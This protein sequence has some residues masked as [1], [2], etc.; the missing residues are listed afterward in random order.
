MG[1]L[2][3]E[4]MGYYNL[5]MPYE[6]AWSILNRIGRLNSLQFVDLNPHENVFNRTYAQHI[7][8]CDEA[9]RRI[10]YL[11]LEQ[12]KFE[13]KTVTS[14]QVSVSP[15]LVDEELRLRD[16]PPQTYFEHLESELERLENTVADQTKKYEQLMERHNQLL[17]LRI[18]LDKSR[19]LMSGQSDSLFANLTGVMNLEDLNRFKR[20]V[21]RATR[22][23]ALTIAIDIEEPMKDPVSGL[24][25]PK[26][27]FIVRYRGN[28]EGAMRQNLVKIC[29]SLGAHRYN[30]PS[31]S[32]DLIKTLAQNENDIS[33]SLAI[34]SKTREQINRVLNELAA[35]EHF[36][37]CSILEEYRLFV[38]KE[39]S[40][41]HNLNMF[42]L[43][44][45]I[46]YGNCWLPLSDEPFVSQ[47]LSDL[48][49]TGLS[50]GQLRRVDG[51][52]P[53]NL[54][55]PTFFRL[56]AFTWAFQEMVNTYGTPRY[57]EANPA[58]FSCVT[59]PF[60]FGIM[61]GDV[62]HG[63]LLT[64]FAAYLCFKKDELTKSDSILKAAL[65]ARYMLLMMG[66]CAFYCGLIYNDFLGIPFDFFG[67]KWS[68]KSG[69]DQ[70]TRDEVYPFGM[71]PKW[72]RA[73]NE[74]IYFNS[75]KMKVAV[76]FGVTQ[77]T[78]GVL[79][80]G[81]NAIHFRSYIDFF[82]EFIPQLT[83][84]LSIFG[85]MVFMIFVKWCSDWGY[86][87]SDSAPNLITT[88]MNIF[89]KGGQ[90]DD[91]SSLWGDRLGQEHLQLFLMILALLCVPMMLL[92]KPL[93]M[94]Y[95][96]QKAAEANPLGLH[97]QYAEFHDNKEAVSGDHKEFEF[98]EVFIHQM[99]ETI[100]FVLGTVSNTASYLRLW[101]LSLAHAQLSK[102]FFEKLVAGAIESDNPAL[103][104]I[105]FF[106]FANATISVL[107]VMDVMECFLHALRLHWVEFMNK[108]FKG[109]G[110]KFT[111][112]S[113]QQ[114][115]IDGRLV[116]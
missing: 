13:I 100:E 74:L 99:I 113:F 41:Y 25:I 96:A 45:Q 102:I 106:F 23:N 46:F 26:V 108:F 43:K 79:F 110:V 27:V 40:I 16:A 55:P 64:G 10:R 3:S 92:P 101:A 42:Q 22:G 88:L 78:A 6:S 8:R 72:Y 89:L 97:V 52:S 29:D 104:V 56:N 70:Y 75:F 54:V 103:V 62:G 37:S 38:L 19:R 116:N 9:E 69:E 44:N 111:P 83:F 49:R 32:E 82:F 30:I 68:K 77:M 5:V 71:D 18:V 28:L 17:E 61:F 14:E 4:E 91:Q 59:F 11:Q 51:A 112:F 39:K 20:M 33:N 85:Y 57:R 115:F 60:L 67:S 95:R 31:S 107:M 73:D 81:A 12:Q 36:G 47:A 1:L 87:W 7:R 50:T 86:N 105:G 24:N 35:V 21:F 15:D 63:S 65:P 76:I 2:R 94:R 34:T 109:E 58:L 48:G 66:M 90:L 114:L 84:M 93:I 80:K 53:S 98:S